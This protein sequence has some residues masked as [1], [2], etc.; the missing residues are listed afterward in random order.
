M[1]N[2]SAGSSRASAAKITVN[3]ADKGH[4]V[5][6]MGMGIGESSTTN[7]ST[8]TNGTMATGSTARKVRTVPP[9][10]Q[11]EP[12]SPPFAVVSSP[13]ETPPDGPATVMAGPSS[14]ALSQK[15]RPHIG[16]RY[17]TSEGTSSGTS[18][19]DS[20]DEDNPW[21]TFTSRGMAKMKARATR[22]RSGDKTEQTVQESGKETA[23]SGAD[24]M[25]S[26]RKYRVRDLYGR[27]KQKSRESN[28]S[29]GRPITTQKPKRR[30]SGIDSDGVAS[31]SPA[32]LVVHPFLSPSAPPTPRELHPHTHFFRRSHWRD[33]PTPLNLQVPAPKLA[34]SN[35]APSSPTRLHSHVMF[36]SPE[37]VLDLDGPRGSG[38]P[39]LEGARPG[40]P[41][42]LPRRAPIMRR[43]STTPYFSRLRR[44][45]GDLTDLP[46]DT[47][48]PSDRD[49]ERIFIRHRK[50][51]VSK[52]SN[53]SSKQRG[54]TNS[55]TKIRRRRDIDEG[56]EIHTDTPM[57]ERNRRRSINKLKLQLPPPISDHFKHGWPQAGSWQDALYGMYPGQLATPP[58]HAEASPSK[59]HRSGTREPRA[60][61]HNM[62]RLS[63]LNPSRRREP[64]HSP[65]ERGIVPTGDAE[66][67]VSDQLAAQDPTSRKSRRRQK[68]KRYRTALVPPTPSGLGFATTDVENGNS[69]AQE[70][71]QGGGVD[72]HDFDWNTPAP[73]GT[74]GPLRAS[75]VEHVPDDPING[76]RNKEMPGNGDALSRQTTLATGKSEA[77]SFTRW[78]C[79]STRMKRRKERKQMRIKEDDW[80]KKAKRVLFL[81]ARV[82]IYIR[83]INLAVVL[84]ALALAVTIRL[85]LDSLGIP[86]VMGS[87]T[88]L[89]ISY[90]SL[91][92]VHVLTAIYREY[93]GRP[94]GLWGLRSKM[95]WVCLD[96]L[97]VG[98]WSSAITDSANDFIATPLMCA[99]GKAWWASDLDP[100]IMTVT[101]SRSRLH[102]RDFYVDQDTYSGFR[103]LEMVLADD[104]TNSASTRDICQRQGACI[105]LSLVALV[106]YGGNMVLS[107]FRIFET[108]RRTANLER[109]MGA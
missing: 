91:T 54:S 97:F 1:V 8:L 87:S 105:G 29:N 34:R 43:Q 74:F 51:P 85:R 57:G 41:L 89:I 104:I 16:R 101:V 27:G 55:S 70:R 83:L 22:K 17:S 63:S 69:A 33:S 13:L 72:P 95:L 5:M 49:R 19:W 108:V 92:S 68:K 86:G 96:L 42:S 25:K 6:K 48:S 40:N 26:D 59:S 47:E 71:Q 60:R 44:A 3:M 11:F 28:D 75:P 12:P 73:T 94:I 88:T 77:A 37:V 38:D 99:R 31:P 62:R 102:A 93:F 58:D 39:I 65:G 103:A 50:I 14:A 7:M 10:A 61:P 24:Q 18:D 90:A 67:D 76:L 52:D 4:S 81:D 109:A 106:L 20:T 36:G 15:R 100:D 23:I 9:S 82:T 56:G 84:A 78:G 79:F 53:E 80:K 46:T 35:S 32:S 45:R 107:L 21:W 66:E 98:L 64:R 30:Q 2:F